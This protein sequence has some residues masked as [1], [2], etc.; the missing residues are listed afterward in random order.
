MGSLWRVSAQGGVPEQIT[1]LDLAGTGCTEHASG[2]PGSNV[3]KRSIEDG[4]VEGVEEIHPEI[5]GFRLPE[6]EL[7]VHGDVHQRHAVVA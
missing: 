3:S 6:G 1:E 7:L 2:C 4:V 5:Q